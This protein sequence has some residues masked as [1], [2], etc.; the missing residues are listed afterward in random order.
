MNTQ[1]VNGVVARCLLEP[2]YL[3]RLA[4]DMDTELASLRIDDATRVE[5]SRL[6]LEKVR[7]LGGLITKVQHN[8]LWDNFPYTRAMLRFYGIELDTF[9]DY[10]REQ[11]E[12][13]RRGRPTSEEKTDN[14]LSFLE[15]RLRAPA[16]DGCP[17]LLEVLTHER[18]QWDVTRR[19]LD[20]DSVAE[21]RQADDPVQTNTPD[22]RIVLTCDILRV[23]A[24]H[25]DPFAIIAD[26]HVGG[27]TLKKNLA[28]KPAC[29]CYW[30]RRDTETVSVL[31][32]DALTATVLAGVDGRRSVRDLLDAAERTLVDATR[33][34]LVHAL[35]QAV[36]V[37][38]VQLVEPESTPTR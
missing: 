35:N 20:G 38:F 5:L 32:V 28:P 25:Y 12:L 26:L 21:T 36:A 31:E 34:D 24:L 33:D 3:D 4:R 9:A 29:Y 18:L 7:R 13:L 15:D 37:G 19:L 2:E 17:G 6:D 27:Q 22:Q 8:N 23:A 30:G 16:G 11:L 10:R 14:F 1:L